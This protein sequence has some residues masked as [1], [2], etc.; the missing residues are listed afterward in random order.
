MI[1]KGYEEKTAFQ[2]RFES[3]TSQELISNMKPEI[4]EIATLIINN[5]K[6]KSLK[7]YFKSDKTLTIQWIYT[8]EFIA[9]A[10]IDKLGGNNYSI[11]FSY[12]VPISL[13]LESSTFSTMFTTEYQKS[14]YD[15]IF[16]AFDYGEG[17]A[18]IFLKELTKDSLKL[19]FCRCS[20]HLD[21]I[22]HHT[23]TVALTLLGHQG[24]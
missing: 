4:I 2:E 5:E 16:N 3:K 19:L 18:N 14:Q 20:I 8:D 1:K 11:N 23:W 9:Y 17:R 7:N 6:E 21:T 12:G 13:Y 22:A 15:V 24:S 10:D